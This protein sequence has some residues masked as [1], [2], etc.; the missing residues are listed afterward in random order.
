MGVGHRVGVAIPLR[1]LSHNIFLS[2]FGF[3]FAETA[4][5]GARYFSFSFSLIN[6]KNVYLFFPFIILQFALI[7]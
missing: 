4:V 6:L 7:T 5:A 1:V 3:S 2:V